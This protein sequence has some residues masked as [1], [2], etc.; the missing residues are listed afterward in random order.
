MKQVPRPESVLY[1][2]VPF[3]PS[4]CHPR[5]RFPWSVGCF[6]PGAQ[7]QEGPSGFL[8]WVGHSSI[9][10]HTVK[11]GG[12]WCAVG[13]RRSVPSSHTLGPIFHPQP[14]KLL[15]KVTNVFLCRVQRPFLSW[16][17]LSWADRS[18]PPTLSPPA[19]NIFL[20]FG[21]G[22]GARVPCPSTAPALFIPYLEAGAH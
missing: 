20:I 1:V 2:V 9:R 15:L 5:P 18:C 19:P 7:N 8:P 12:L 4:D 10:W 17:P 6:L 11:Q 16:P 22:G 14:K 13:G 3:L 21:P